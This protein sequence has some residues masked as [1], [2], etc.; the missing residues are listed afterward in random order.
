MSNV[1]L[2]IN[3]TLHPG[4]QHI[5]DTFVNKDV[6]DVTRCVVNTGRQVGKT[7]LAKLSALQWMIDYPGCEVGWLTP[8]NKHF[9][10]VIEWFKMLP[11]QFIKKVDSIKNVVYM[12]NGSVIYFYSVDNYEAIRGQTFEFRIM[13]EFAFGRFSQPEAI[14]A[15]DPTFVAKGIKD[16]ILSTPLGKNQHYAAFQNA[17]K[18][19][20]EMVY[21]MKTEDNPMIDKKYLRKR[22]LELTDSQY[23]QEYEGV[24]NEGGGE[25]FTGIDQVCVLDDYTINEANHR[26]GFGVDWASKNDSSVL[27]I[28]DLDDGKVVSIKNSYADNYNVIVNEF[29]AVLSNYNI[30]TGY[31]ELNGV[32][33][34]AYDMLRSVVPQTIGFTMSQSSKQELVSLT[35]TKIQNK[36]VLLPSREL[37]PQLYNELSDYQQRVSANGAYSYSHPKGKH[38]DYVDS[39]MLAVYS[40][41]E[42]FKPTTRVLR[43]RPLRPNFT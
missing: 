12:A 22:K 30:E 24:F 42:Q 5:W 11:K 17:E 8:E 33:Q 31:A 35:R 36:E 34:P 20:D 37:C 9:L 26:Y 21:Q 39:F 29:A 38:D 10:K 7:T 14:A 40:L 27:T 15:Y 1:S 18:R 28:I 13:D 43:S 16:L 32:G 23:K 3:V 25:V 2:N 41:R 6:T 19:D 4:Q